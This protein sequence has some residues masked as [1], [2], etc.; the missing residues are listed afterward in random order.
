MYADDGLIY[1]NGT[2]PEE[3]AIWFA[4]TNSKYGIEINHEKSKFAKLPDQELNLKFLGMRLKGDTLSAETREGSVLKYDK[5][6]L[7]R[8][9]DMLEN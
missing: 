3:Q 9:Y 6:D 1:G 4:L 2:P 8:I 7:V 5:H